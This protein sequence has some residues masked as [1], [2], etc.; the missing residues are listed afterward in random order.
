MAYTRVAIMATNTYRVY[1]VVI[2]NP[3]PGVELIPKLKLRDRTPAVG[4]HTMLADI[5]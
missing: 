1:I 4:S 5:A 3:N 2:A